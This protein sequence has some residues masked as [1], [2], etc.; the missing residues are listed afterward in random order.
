MAPFG[1]APVHITARNFLAYE[2]T[3]FVKA[4]VC[5]IQST[6]MV[7]LVACLKHSM[8]SSHMS[9]GYQKVHWL[10]SV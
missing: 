3:I 4:T 7:A 5:I 10:P 6:K 8:I 2:Q 9:K 1:N